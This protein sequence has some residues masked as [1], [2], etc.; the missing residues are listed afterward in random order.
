[1]RFYLVKTKEDH[2]YNMDDQITYVNGNDYNSYVMHASLSWLLQHLERPVVLIVNANITLSK[3][4]R[5]NDDSVKAHIIFT[6]SYIDK[7]IEGR[8]IYYKLFDKDE[9]NKKMEAAMIA[10]PDMTGVEYV[11]SQVFKPYF[12]KLAYYQIPNDYKWL[13]RYKIRLDVN[14]DEAFYTSEDHYTA[15][16]RDGKIYFEYLGGETKGLTNL[17]YDNACYVTKTYYIRNKNLIDCIDWGGM[18]VL[19]VYDGKL[20]NFRI[21]TIIYRALKDYS[22]DYLMADANEYG[23]ESFIGALNTLRYYGVRDLL[24]IYPNGS[25]CVNLT[26]SQIKNGAMKKFIKL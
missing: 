24:Q 8:E 9:I 2:W 19:Y 18:K 14:E 7:F 15:Y 10:A 22:I 4:F 26:P 12:N 16:R 17:I 25:Y 23:V 11:R 1:M 6:G 21:Y 5:P 20:F 13:N 3:P